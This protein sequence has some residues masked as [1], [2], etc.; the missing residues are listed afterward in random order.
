[1]A[2]VTVLRINTG[3][4]T[5]VFVRNNDITTVNVRDGDITTLMSA[6]ATVNV[7]NI[8]FSDA[9][10]SAIAR[11]TTSGVSSFVS[12]ADHSH[13]GATLLLDGGNY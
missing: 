3:D 7:E 5:N 6:P 13:S 9:T 1:M 10:P 12:R 4:I 8:E 11:T 2:D